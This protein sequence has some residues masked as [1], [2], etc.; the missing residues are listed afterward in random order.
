MRTITI[1]G[2]L[3]LLVIAPLVVGG[4]G[5][6]KDSTSSSSSKTP[7]ASELIEYDLA[8]AGKAWNGWTAKAPKGCK[9]MEDL[10]KAARLACDGP[11]MEDRSGRHG[12]D[13]AFAQG[14]ADLAKLKEQRA[15]RWAKAKTA[16]EHVMLAD[17]PDFLAWREGKDKALTFHF[18]RHMKV[19]GQD[20]TCKT[21]LMIGGGTEAEH[22]LHLAACRTLA[23][24]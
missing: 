16:G 6:G 10:G 22:A 9:V 24:K 8:P 13:I 4:A 14:H 12:F 15:D 1:P 3:A 23:K 11:G 21:N 7:K 5:C 19:A 17:K 2:R 18:L 20:F